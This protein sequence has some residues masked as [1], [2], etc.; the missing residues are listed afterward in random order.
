[1]SVRGKLVVLLLF[2][3]LL[4][5]L[6][7][8]GIWGQLFYAVQRWQGEWHRELSRVVAAMR[9]ED[10]AWWPLVSAG[11][12]Y[13]ILHAAGPGHGKAVVVTFLASQ[14]HGGYRSAVALAVGGALLQ[15]VSAIF[16]VGVTVGAAQWLIR[17]TVQQVV[18]ANRLSILLIAGV[19]A[20]IVYRQWQ[21]LQRPGCHCCAHHDGAHHHHSPHPQNGSRREQWL[22]MLG[23]GLRPCSGAIMALAVAGSWGLWG[24]GIMMTLAMALGT[25]CTV[26]LLAVLTVYG[27]QY[28]LQESA[29][30]KWRDALHGVALMGGVVLVL[31]AALMLAVSFAPQT[32]PLI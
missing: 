7:Q 30:G 19:G 1:M 4:L 13:G 10:A 5:G 31:L 18:W 23:I 3:L 17:E 6:W 27:R 26:L 15:A 11:F 16:W 32:L 14:Q 21:A 28:V 24:A 12:V 20:Y 25:A 8:G 29:S 2:L 22:A 9:R